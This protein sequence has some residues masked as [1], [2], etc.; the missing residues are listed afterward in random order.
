MLYSVKLFFVSLFSVIGLFLRPNLFGYDSYAFLALVKGF[1]QSDW[2]GS[3]DLFY[4]ILSVLPVSYLLYVWVMWFCLFVSI[5][6]LFYGLKQ[7][8]SEQTAFLATL[9]CLGAA[10]ILI[11]SFAQFQNELLA[12]PFLFWSFYCLMAKFKYHN[13]VALAFVGIAYF[14]WVGSVAWIA[15]VGFG[16]VL[17]FLF[18]I[19]V[20]IP[21]WW[22][23][24]GWT[25]T[26]YSGVAFNTYFWGL[27]DLFLLFPFI[28]VLFWQRNRRWQVWLLV[29]LGLVLFSARFTI[30][31]VPFIAL[32]IAFACDEWFLKRTSA[33]SI[34]W[35]AVFLIICW[36]VAIYMQHPQSNE[37]NLVH[38]FVNDC[39]IS[40]NCYND[41][42]I[43]WWVVSEGGATPFKASPPE[44]DY[45]QLAKPF[46][47]LTVRDL[48]CN[49]IEHQ[50][51]LNY[52]QCN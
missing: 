23:K 32:G 7:V 19:V 43:G 15:I 6:G 29:S 26:S 25:F 2:I 18:A 38:T 4:L 45:N 34:V 39:K 33:K 31:S 12:Y 14:F 42:S 48:N 49:L 9:I 37:L 16:W 27:W 1:T 10:P 24:I 11:F 40:Q 52:Y 44:P 50:G 17:P 5:L 30:L 13:W 41:W 46:K 47:A 51:F 21:F 8:F 28:F 22:S 20:S 36:N 3:H 35:C